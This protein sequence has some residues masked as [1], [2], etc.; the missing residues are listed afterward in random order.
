MTQP[1]T[2]RPRY[3]RIGMLAVS[4]GVTALS[5]LG[6]FGVLRSSAD[7]QVSSAHQHATLC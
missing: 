7:D 6:G 4:L 5:V 1:T 3:G 2:V